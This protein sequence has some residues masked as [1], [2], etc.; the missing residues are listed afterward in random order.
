MNLLQSHLCTISY[1]FA[2]NNVF[3]TFHM[4]SL[5]SPPPPTSL[6]SLFLIRGRQCANLASKASPITRHF[7]RLIGSR[8]CNGIRNYLKR[9]IGAK[10]IILRMILKCKFVFQRN[11]LYV[12]IK[13]ILYYCNAHNMYVTIHVFQAITQLLNIN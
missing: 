7:V 11:F 8:G 4:F 10:K 3:P 6:L 12:F 2:I 13:I 1:V 5:N 9:G